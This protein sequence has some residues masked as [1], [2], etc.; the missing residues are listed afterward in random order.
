VRRSFV[1][2]QIEAV[3]P[4][5]IGLANI[6]TNFVVNQPSF[7]ERTG[8]CGQSLCDVPSGATPSLKPETVASS[9][10]HF[11]QRVFVVQHF[12]IGEIAT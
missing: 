2:P 11:S 9:R 12:A 8:E 3:R 7:F 1:L 10:P 6:A 5:C 4:Y